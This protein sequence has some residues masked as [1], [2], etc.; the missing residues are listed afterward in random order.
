MIDGSRCLGWSSSGPCIARRVLC[1]A[2]RMGQR[3]RQ[4]QSALGDARKSRA[5]PRK[6]ACSACLHRAHG[7][8]GRRSLRTDYTD[9]GQLG[10]GMTWRGRRGRGSRRSRAWFLACG[11]LERVFPRF[12]FT[13]TFLKFSLKWNGG[14][15]TGTRISRP[16]PHWVPGYDHESNLQPKF[17]DAWIHFRVCKACNGCISGAHSDV[18]K[19]DKIGRIWSRVLIIGLQFVR[20]T[21]LPGYRYLS[22]RETL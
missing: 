6:T 19:P 12:L 20:T 22:F 9:R 1:R 17:V 8:D 10:T 5:R 14:F 2:R 3:S 11:K 15:V 18:S 21:N 4:L 13:T 7:D 16:R